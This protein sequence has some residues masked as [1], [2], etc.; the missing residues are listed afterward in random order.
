MEITIFMACTSNHTA[1]GLLYNVTFCVEK[2]ILS[3]LKVT[4]ERLY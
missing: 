2:N 4:D 3:T 1:L